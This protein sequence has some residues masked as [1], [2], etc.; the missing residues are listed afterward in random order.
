MPPAPVA[1]TEIRSRQPDVTREGTR[2]RRSYLR[3]TLEAPGAVPTLIPP[4]LLLLL[5]L[6]LPPPYACHRHSTAMPTDQLSQSAMA[7]ATHV[8]PYA[9]AVQ[10]LTAVMSPPPPRRHKDAVAVNVDVQTAGVDVELGVM[11]SSLLQ[12]LLSSSS[13][14]VSVASSSSPSS[15]ASAFSSSMSAPA[16]QS[17]SASQS[18]SAYVPFSSLLSSYLSISIRLAIAIVIPVSVC[19]PVAVSATIRLGL[20]AGGAGR[21]LAEA[22]ACSQSVDVRGVLAKRS[23]AKRVCG[24]AEPKPEPE[25]EHGPKHESES[26]W[27]FAEPKPEHKWVRTRGGLEHEHEPKPERVGGALVA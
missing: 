8:V 1:E 24:G 25:H 6:L 10:I 11:L 17:A 4:L 21:A 18:Q 7:R 15:S 20:E 2:S 16:S 3:Q 22:G 9:I 12:R 23:L 19:L 27:A 14:S 13:T 5:R 26:R